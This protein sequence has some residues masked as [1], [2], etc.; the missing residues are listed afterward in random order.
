MP[1]PIDEAAARLA[2]SAVAHRRQQVLA[3]INVPYWYWAFL[4]GG[5]MALGALGDFAAGWVL[6]VCT[7]A[8]G[9]VHAVI[10]RRVVSGRSG[11]SQLSIRS[12]LVTAQVPLAIG[13]FVIVMAIATI[14]VALLLHADGTR[15][16]ALDA[17]IV[18]GMLV[19][20][21]GPS[22][23]AGLRRRALARS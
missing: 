15:H 22:L 6:S 11:S 16:P 3:E 5:W 4:A 9:A 13:A 8:F 18:V 10:G 20:T 7:L 21:G 12:E 23:V 2:L 17:G 19:F 14:A 1:I